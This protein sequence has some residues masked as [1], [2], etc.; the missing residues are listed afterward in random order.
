MKK[1]VFI[2]S[3][4]VLVTVIL[5]AIDSFYCQFLKTSFEAFST[6]LFPADENARGELFKIIL[7]IVGAIAITFGL[8]IS[9]RRARAMERGVEKQ[10]QSIENQNKQLELSRKAQTDER[11]KNAIEHLGSEKEPV[12]LGGISELHQIAKENKVDYSEVV[13]NILCS[14]IKTSAD[15]YSK[16]ANDINHKAIQTII[17]YLFKKNSNQGIYC[18]LSCNISYTNLLGLDLTNCNFKKGNLSSCYLPN[19]NESDLSY[20]NIS[21][22]VL[23]TSK[24]L[25]V[26]LGF[27]D[28]YNTIFHY[29][30]IKNTN[31][32]NSNISQ[33][34][35]LEC[36]IEN[37]KCEGI[38]FHEV[39]FSASLVNNLSLN[40]SSILSAN[41]LLAQV[42]NIDFSRLKLMGGCDFR[43]ASFNNVIFKNFITSSKF[44]GANYEVNDYPQLY[45]ERITNRVWKECELDIP[46]VE[47]G[48]NNLGVLTDEDIKEIREKIISLEKKEIH[49]I[50]N[51]KNNSPK[52]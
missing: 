39:D 26:E 33:T 29:C 13:F 34:I 19:L 2:F 32:N 37:L 36:D 42:S 6:Y 35:F 48:G 30:E 8:Y 3:F 7:S 38:D 28:L 22:S 21:N 17:N 15:I 49:F 23:K 12:I 50:E 47:Y 14:Y 40:N 27:S 16:K 41:F 44:N 52:Q 5:I 20:G 24:L 45:E 31:F 51:K 9:Y 25:D 18:H 46:N 43:G 11:F 4:L 1:K 10:A